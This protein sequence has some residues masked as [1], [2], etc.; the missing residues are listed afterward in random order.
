MARGVNKVILLGRVQPKDP[1]IRYTQSGKGVCS[2][3]LVTDESYKDKDGTKHEQATWHRVEFWGKAAD[4]IMQ[5]VKKGDPLYVEGR[6]RQEQWEEN[7]V[8]KYGQ[9]IVGD[10]FRFVG[11]G[12]R[13]DDQPETT[14]QPAASNDDDLPF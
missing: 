5:Y 14:A 10:Q 8:T 1:E 11:G 9:K 12:K 6:I 2:F 4:V 3:K 13:D 7:G